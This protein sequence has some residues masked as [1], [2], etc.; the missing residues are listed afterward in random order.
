MLSLIVMYTNIKINLVRTKFLARSS[1]HSYDSCMKNT[2]ASET[3]TFIGLM[4]LRGL[5]VWTNHYVNILFNDLSG[6]RIFG[7]TMSKNRFKFFLLTSVLMT[8]L[9]G[10][11]VGFMTNV[12]PS[13]TNSNL[14]TK[15]VAVASFLTIF[16][17]SMKLFTP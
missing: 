5:L 2:T 7:A 14:L 10:L 9:Q 4:Y 13:A 15:I 8:T 12:L 3:L 6:H 17:R 11:N 1:D 16:F